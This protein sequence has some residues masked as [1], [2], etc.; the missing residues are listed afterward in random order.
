MA[1]RRLFKSYFYVEYNGQKYL[2]SGTVTIPPFE[3]TGGTSSFTIH[4]SKSWE[5]NDKPS[6]ISLNHDDGKRGSTSIIATAAANAGSSQRTNVLRVGLKC[7]L[8][9]RNINIALTQKSVGEESIVVLF[10]NP[11][12]GASTTSNTFTITCTAIDLSSLGYYAAGSDGIVSCDISTSSVTIAANEGYVDRTITLSI[13]GTSTVGN[14][15]TDTAQFVQTKKV[16]SPVLGITY[17]GTGES[18]SGG[19]TSSFSLTKQY[20]TEITQYAVSPNTASV[21][22]TGQTGLTVVFPQNQTESVRQYTVSVSGTDVYGI[23]RTGQTTFNQSADT[24]SFTVTP[25]AQTIPWSATSAVFRTA[26]VNVANVG[27]YPATSENINSCAKNGDVYTA[28]VSPNTE[29]TSKT[30]KFVASGNSVGGRT[31]YASGTTVQD[32]KPDAG[33]IVVT[34]DGSQIGSGATSVTFIVAWTG[35]GAGTQITLDKTSAITSFT[36]SV[37]NV[38]N[39]TTSS[40]TV[41][42][43]VSANPD[44]AQRLA[45]LSASGIDDLSSARTDSGYYVQA[46]RHSLYSLTIVM[47]QTGDTLLCGFNGGSQEVVATNT[48]SH[49]ITG[50]VAGDVVAY[51]M[52]KA[53][54]VS[55]T[56]SITMGNSD[57]TIYLTLFENRFEF[58]VTPWDTSDPNNNLFKVTFFE[59]SNLIGDAILTGSSVSTG[60]GQH[61]FTLPNDYVIS[62]F[63][64]DSGDF[65]YQIEYLAGGLNIT[66]GYVATPEASEGTWVNS[67]AGAN[68][69]MSHMGILKAKSVRFAYL[70]TYQESAS[71]TPTSIIWGQLDS[72]DFYFN[73]NASGCTSVTI[74]WGEHLGLGTFIWYSAEGGSIIQTGIGNG[75]T[76]TPTGGAAAFDDKPIVL[77]TDVGQQIGWASGAPEGI[78]LS[79]DFVFTFRYANGSTATRLVNYQP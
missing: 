9:R 29:N 53:G 12:V 44:T 61:I 54:F 60:S 36:P 25:D 4:S 2:N 65:K 57:E 23:L 59:N 28:S 37:I 8:D 30:I 72:D 79:G 24:Y 75:D 31:V 20:I 78:S 22:N 69:V 76:I 62:G 5:I 34:P 33:S 19:S 71:V 16:V 1:R 13:T 70:G 48:S 6:W 15:V 11:S 73:A 17:T 3:A 42:A 77:Y 56:S 51:T 66:S 49:T 35:M 45:S 55:S 38:E 47:P 10:D 58:V 63:G 41:T 26:Q 68:V 40:V 43:D 52:K 67:L 74:S 14:P 7:F 32:G 27:Y 21:T 50:L 39:N 18:A 46:A 64:R